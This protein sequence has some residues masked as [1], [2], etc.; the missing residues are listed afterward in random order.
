M[1]GES[2]LDDDEPTWGINDMT[3]D[4]ARLMGQK[5]LKHFQ[6]LYE[7]YVPMSYKGYL[8]KMKSLGVV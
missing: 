5:L 4:F 7:G 6:K 3:R 8:K 2:Q 1:I